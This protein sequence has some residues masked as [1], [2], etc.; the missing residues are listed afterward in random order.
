MEEIW[1]DIE[2]YEGLYQVSNLGR[3]KSLDRLG[4]TGYKLKGKM[5]K[6]WYIK[7]GYQRVGLNKDS[8]KINY[9]VHRLVAQAFI[10]NKENKPFINH[11]NGIKDDNGVDN[12]EWCTDEENQSH[13]IKHGLNNN[14][15]E[16]SGRAKLT[17]Q[18]VI[19]IRK[20]YKTGKYLQKDLGAEYDV[21][22]NT[23]CQIITRKYWKHI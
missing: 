13:A 11:K 12:L 6:L 1:K 18:Q 15:G 7:Q 19:Q 23:I 4:A 10:P 8:H 17:K 21:A 14:I 9:L 22:T 20:K 2:G 3:V 16:L 5:R